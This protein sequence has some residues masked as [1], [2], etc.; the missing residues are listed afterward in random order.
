MNVKL[1]AEP[2]PHGVLTVGSSKTLLPTNYILSF[3]GERILLART[4]IKNICNS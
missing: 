1:I 2:L 4:K 3:C